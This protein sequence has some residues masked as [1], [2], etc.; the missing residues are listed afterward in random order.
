[1]K[2][3]FALILFVA[4]TVTVSANANETLT[5]EPDSGAYHF[6]SSYRIEIGAPANRVWD[7][8]LNFGSWM[9]DFEMS[10][11]HGE[12]KKAGQVLRLYPGQDFFVQI[13]GMVPNETLVIANLPVTFR[14]EHST[15]IGV[16]TLNEN[17]GET[18]LNLSMSRRYTLLES[19]DNSM[20]QTRQSAGFA[21]GTK[22]TWQRFMERLKSLAEN[23][24]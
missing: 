18:V 11:H 4:L 22:A 20:K 24:A 17:N 7:H 8:L 21:E 1:M 3:K 2:F 19:S 9:I 15:G 6:V 23:A 13:V 10:H 5:E 16:I 14:G 12:P